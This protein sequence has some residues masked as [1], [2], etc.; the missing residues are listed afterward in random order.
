[1]SH[2][3]HEADANLAEIARLRTDLELAHEALSQA[4]RAL[5]AERAA[6][7]NAEADAAALVLALRGRQTCEICG[8]R[9]ITW[10]DVQGE[11]E[12]EACEC[13]IFADEALAH[14]RPGVA[15]LVE[16]D[17]LRELVADVARWRESIDA[18]DLHYVFETM[19]KIDAMNAGAE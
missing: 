2:E 11:A 14:P 1:M 4:E 3:A 7:R 8:G 5:L 19:D 17:L 6:R 10:T 18:R 13:W 12:A 16:L 15:L 9:G